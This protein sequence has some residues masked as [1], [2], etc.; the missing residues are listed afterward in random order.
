[1][2]IRALRK[3]LAQ[4][5]HVKGFTPA[6]IVKA[7][8]HLLA[9]ASEVLKSQEAAPAAKPATQ[10]GVDS[11]DF[12]QMIKDVQTK[13]DALDDKDSEIAKAYSE[14]ITTIKATQQKAEETAKEFAD[15]QGK[16]FAEQQKKIEEQNE[17]LENQKKKFDEM[18]SRWAVADEERRQA[19]I[20]LFCESLEKEDHLPATI[21]VVKRY[22]FAD[23]GS[24]TME[25]SEGEG[26]EKKEVKVNLEKMFKEILDS[27]PKERRAKLSENL[28]GEGDD[29]PVVAAK[30]EVN[31]SD[32]EKPV[33][34]DDPKRRARA[35]SRAGYKVKE[36]G[37]I[38]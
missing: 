17:A 26:E 23:V 14:Q 8:E 38:Q 10:E 21:E 12:E 2:D 29:T 30:T 6:E 13:L 35:L 1:M 22:M 3:A 28:R 36:A 34:I 19:Q 32:E 27:I 37:D 4:W 5:N 7:K 31:L 15:D 33:N 16:K 24:F 9:H 11:M 20:S 18:E 25:F